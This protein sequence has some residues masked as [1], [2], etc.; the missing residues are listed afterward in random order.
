MARKFLINTS[1]AIQTNLTTSST[2]RT[3]AIWIRLDE[4][5]GAISNY[6]RI[7]SKGT[8]TLDE[9]FRWLDDQAKFDFRVNWT[10]TGVW[11]I[12]AP[13]ID[14]YHH[15]AITY[16]SGSSSNTPVIYLDGVSVTVT[17]SSAPSGSLSTTSTG[18]LV[19]N[20]GFSPSNSGAG[21]SLLEWA[22]WNRIL[23]QS[24]ITQ[25]ANGLPANLLD[26]P[27][28]YVRMLDSDT[29]DKY[30]S[31]PTVTGTTVTPDPPIRHTV[32]PNVL[33][34]RIFMPGLA[35]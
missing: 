34:P 12:D 14:V 11:T 30:N 25:L 9:Q 31:A 8:A 22:I 7:W 33:R 10:S 27:V 6:G 19:G 35:K 18:Y 17:T 5:G 29:S 24:E 3:R 13:A 21:A 23:T 16:D 32:K 2:L 26:T 1:D 20:N 15:Y 28:S 4:S